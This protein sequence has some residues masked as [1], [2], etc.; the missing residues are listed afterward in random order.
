MNEMTWKTKAACRDVDPSLFFP[1][2]DYELAEQNWRAKRV[3]MSCPVLAECY[4]AYKDE[5]YGIFGGTTAP[6]RLNHISKRRTTV[7]KVWA[8]NR[9]RLG[10][11]E[12]VIPV[13]AQRRSEIRDDVLYLHAH[14]CD[15]KEISEKLDLPRS[16]VWSIINRSQRVA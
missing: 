7:E 11:P 10:M 15:N 1:D 8:K 2:G 16:T 13:S 5:R 14:G 9:Q 6:E 4:D 3:C 12:V